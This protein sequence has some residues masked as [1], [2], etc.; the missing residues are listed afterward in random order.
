[1]CNLSTS[2]LLGLA[3]DVL[4]PILRYSMPDLLLSRVGTHVALRLLETAPRF[5]ADR[6][7]SCT[8]RRRCIERCMAVHSVVRLRNVPVLPSGALTGFTNAVRL[9]YARRAVACVVCT[10]YILHARAPVRHPLGT[11]CSR[12]AAAPPGVRLIR[13]SLR[14]VHVYNLLV[15]VRTRT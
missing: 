8:R 15:S 9:P 2:G 11:C 4:L 10:R 14:D 3:A 12:W 1:M 13:V 5:V 6:T 7:C